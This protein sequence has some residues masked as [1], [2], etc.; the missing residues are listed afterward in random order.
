VAVNVMLWS[1]TAFGVEVDMEVV[2]EAAFTF[3]VDTEEPE[4]S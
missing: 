4:A 3:W 2:V 1:V